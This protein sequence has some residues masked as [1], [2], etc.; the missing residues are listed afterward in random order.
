MSGTGQTAGRHGA[1]RYGCQEGNATGEVAM[2][3]II[4]F[5][6]DGVGDSVFEPHDIQVMSM[7]LDQCAKS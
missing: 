7:A 1:L 2:A 4:P 3:T 6:R 5:L